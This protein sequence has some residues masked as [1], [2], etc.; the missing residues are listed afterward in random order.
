MRILSL[1]IAAVTAILASCTPTHYVVNTV[2]YEDQ[3]KSKPSEVVIKV[4]DITPVGGFNL[5]AGATLRTEQGDINISDSGVSTDLVID[6]RG[7][8]IDPTARNPPASAIR[9]G[10]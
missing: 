9:A 6:L 3:I 1:L 10:K 7:I 2:P 5:E 8:G 4:D